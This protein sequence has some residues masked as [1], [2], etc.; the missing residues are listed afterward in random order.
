MGARSRIEV[1]T[2]SARETFDFTHFLCFPL[3]ES[4]LE[5]KF[6]EF[7]VG[8]LKD[9]CEVGFY[10]THVSFFFKCYNRNNHLK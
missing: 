7:K 2:E 5:K 6:E 9:F 3:Y 10:Q 8:V 1:I 4:N